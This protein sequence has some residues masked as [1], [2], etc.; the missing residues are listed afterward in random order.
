MNIIRSMDMDVLLLQ[1]CAVARENMEHKVFM[2][3]A[4]VFEVLSLYA[5]RTC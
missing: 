3:M 1:F 2:R 4:E 5:K